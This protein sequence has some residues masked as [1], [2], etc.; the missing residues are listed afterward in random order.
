M[1]ARMTQTAARAR[2]FMSGFTSGQRSVVIVGGLALVLGAFALTRWV[3]Q[4]TWAP[5]YG[6]LS[7]N[8]ANAIVDQLRSDGVQYK[9]TDGGATILVPQSQVYDERVALSGKGLP[10]SDS[11]GGWSLLDKQGITATDFQQNVA[12]QRALEGELGKTLGAITGVRTAVVHL[13]IPKKDVFATDQDAPTASVLVGLQPGVTLDRGQI[14]AITHLVAGSVPELDPA[15]VTVTDATGRLLSAPDSGNA[16]DAAAAAGDAD[17]QTAQYEDRLGT[18]VQR[19]LDQVLGAGKSVVRINAQLDYSSRDTTSERFVQETG[20]D[21]LSEATV[22]ETYV[23]AGDSAGGTLGQIAPTPVT[24][25]TG[26]GSYARQ[27]R[28]VENPVGKIVDRTQAAPG[29]VERLTV[30]V[31]LDSKAAGA[32][33]AS[34]VEALVSNAVGLNT[35]RGDTVQISTLPFDTTAAAAATKDIAAAQKAAKTAQYIQLGKKA[36]LGLLVVIILFL[37]MRRA[38]PKETVISATASDL[39]AEGLVLPSG[40]QLA[41]GGGSDLPQLPAED[42]VEVERS[43]ERMRTEVAELVDNQPEDVAAMLQGW[44]AERRA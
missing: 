12:Y 19:M 23:G 22:S 3:A 33:D 9:L 34:Q 1:N 17:A 28:T 15:K 7:G 30:A 40:T 27:Q 44:L 5:L 42:P 39:P 32:I 38:K 35:T 10:A 2:G 18:A 8:D 16:A 14:R 11:G 37:A 24:G 4:P 43:K 31:A 26:N 29:T 6:N 21:P 13:A 20:V 36:G 25:A 41:L